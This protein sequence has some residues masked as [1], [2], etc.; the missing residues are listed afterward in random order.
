M[1]CFNTV[2]MK[3]RDKNPSKL[4]IKRE[5]DIKKRKGN[6]LKTFSKHE[7]TKKMK[8]ERAYNY[9]KGGEEAQSPG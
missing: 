5:K 7:K 4:L 3:K 9:P 8:K 1:K 6:E 2:G